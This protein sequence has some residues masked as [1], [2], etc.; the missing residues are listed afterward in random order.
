MIGWIIGTVCV[1]GVGFV[2]W[3][4]WLKPRGHNPLDGIKRRFGK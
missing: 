4:C 1:I 3:K 2:V